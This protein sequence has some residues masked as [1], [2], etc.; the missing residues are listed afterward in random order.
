MLF[1]Q[2][3]II[4]LRFGLKSNNFLV[5]SRLTSYL[6]SEVAFGFIDKETGSYWD[7]LD[8]YPERLSS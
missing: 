8:S 7:Q 4:R 5:S 6:P 2:T 3:M 1:D